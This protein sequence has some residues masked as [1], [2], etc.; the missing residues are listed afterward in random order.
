MV[1]KIEIRQT[2]VKPRANGSI[3][4]T[5]LHN[6]KVDEKN[7]KMNGLNG[8]INET[9]KVANE[10]ITKRIN[11]ENMIRVKT[12]HVILKPFRGDKILTE[13]RY[14]PTYRDDLK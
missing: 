6:H 2:L 1:I 12:F 7:L 10:Y 9:T 14:S 4:S 13:Y 3:V 11:K 5:F 8:A